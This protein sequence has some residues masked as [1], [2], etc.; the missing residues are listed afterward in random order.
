MRVALVQWDIQEGYPEKN[1]EKLLQLLSDV[2]LDTVDVLVLPEMWNTGYALSKLEN[3]ADIDGKESLHLLRQ[4]AQDHQVT[5]VGGSVATKRGQQFFNTAYTVSSDGQ[6][7]NHYDKVHLFGLMNE[8]SYLTA[9]Q[10]ESQFSLSDCQ[11]SHVICYDIRFPE[12]IRKQMARGSEVLFVSAQ[13]P[14][15]R[16]AQWRILLQARA[17]ENQAFVVAV[18]RIGQ[19]K[20]DTFDGHS[21]V[22]NPLGD[23]LLETD[24]REGIFVAELDMEA[25]RQVRGQIPVFADRRLDLY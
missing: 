20:A 15:E 11:A 18:N 16:I 19:G 13:W 24:D 7:L 6:L 4:L 23:I 17:I 21:L 3:S 1:R 12:W 22:V 14:K 5:I 10:S 8:D 2:N 25:V 9:G